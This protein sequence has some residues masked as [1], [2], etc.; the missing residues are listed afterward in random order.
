MNRD[1]PLLG[2]VEFYKGAHEN[3]QLLGAADIPLNRFRE[4]TIA[5]GKALCRVRRLIFVEA[6]MLDNNGEKMDTMLVY[7]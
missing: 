6:V 3:R 4:G 2:T 7:R 5:V 1:E